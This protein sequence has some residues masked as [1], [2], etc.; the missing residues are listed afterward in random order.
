MRGLGRAPERR[1][2]EQRAAAPG[3]LGER[4]PRPEA[5]D[6]QHEDV[7]HQQVGQQVALVGTLHAQE[8]GVRSPPSTASTA[9]LSR[10]LRTATNVPSR[11]T[12]NI[13]VNAAAGPIKP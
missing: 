7:E 2:Q 8:H 12:A 1:Q 3:E 11:V 13:E 9:V 6:Q 5:R 10:P 4:G